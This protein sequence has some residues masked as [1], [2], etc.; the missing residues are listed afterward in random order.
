MMFKNKS[1]DGMGSAG[2]HQVI[3]GREKVRRKDGEEARTLMYGGSGQ[4]L[5]LA[6]FGAVRVCTSALAL[7]TC[8]HLGGL[9]V[10]SKYSSYEAIRD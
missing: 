10:D 5:P 1:N 3:S 2:S 7:P 8:G 6:W 9:S 4:V